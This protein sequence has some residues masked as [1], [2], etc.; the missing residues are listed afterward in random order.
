MIVSLLIFAVSP[1]IFAFNS[2]VF[3]SAPEA[4]FSKYT[5]IA[6]PGRCFYVGQF[7]MKTASSLAIDVQGAEVFVAPLSADEKPANYFDRISYDEI[8]KK[9]ADIFSSLFLYVYQGEGFKYV[10]KEEA[11][12]FYKAEFREN[13][14]YILAKAYRD[15]KVFRYCYY[16]K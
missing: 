2:S 14:K 6:L 4:D 10:E 9:H 12:S 13:E 11:D 3:D 5:Q 16:V 8:A 15:N 7:E 1:L